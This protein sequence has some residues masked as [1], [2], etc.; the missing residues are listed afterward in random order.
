MAAE[1]AAFLLDDAMAIGVEQI[2]EIADLGAQLGA[3]VGV[4]HQHTVG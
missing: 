2:F 4:G 3:L 1:S